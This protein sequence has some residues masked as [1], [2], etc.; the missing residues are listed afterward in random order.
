MSGVLG[1]PYRHMDTRSLLAAI[2][3]TRW[4]LAD[5]D[6]CPETWWFP[7]ESRTFIQSQL[8]DAEAERA[9]RERLRH[10]PLAPDWPDQRAE[11]DHLKQAL[12]LET[13]VE[14]L[15]GVQFSRAGRRVWT[16]CPLP[17][18]TADVSPSF[19]IQ[20]EKGLFMCFGCGRGGDAFTFVQLLRDVSFKE[21]I[22]I[23]AAEAGIERRPGR[24]TTLRAGRVRVA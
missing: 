5:I 14:R 19:C 8:A 2:E 12:P 13:L 9:R 22:D 3:L 16:S 11:L 17:G 10:H 4:D 15:A 1:N 6:V 20:P 24:V 18:H 7:V 23:V 21:A